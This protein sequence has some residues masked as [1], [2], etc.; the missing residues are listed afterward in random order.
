MTFAARAVAIWRTW[1]V[2]VSLSVLDQAVTSG[3]NLALNV[4]LARLLAPAAYGAFA[5]AYAVL[6]IVTGFHTALFT[7]PLSALG[8]RVFSGDTRRYMRGVMALNVAVTV[9]L[10]V[11]VGTLAWIDAGPLIRSREWLFAV[12]AAIP[13][14]LSLWLLRSG[15]YLESRPGTALA[16]SVTYAVVLFGGLTWAHAE[17]RVTAPVAL[18]LVG[19]A[20]AIACVPLAF[21]TGVLAG[22]WSWH[23]ATT[24]A[25]AHWQF[26]R[27]ILG[28]SAAHA[29]ANGMYVPLLGAIAGLE[30]SA[31]LRALQN[32]QTPLVRV[33]AGISMVA[34]PLMAQ[35]VAA[36]GA[37]YLKERGT[38]FVMLNMALAAAYA[39]TLAAF[40]RPIFS[41]L[42]GSAFY[43]SYAWL[44]PLFAA[45]A[46]LAAL[47]QCLGILVR[48]ANRPAAVLWA[49][50]GA[51]LWLVVA[52]WA[53]LRTLGVNGAVLS[54]GGS[55]AIESAVYL[56]ALRRGRSATTA[57]TVA[58]TEDVP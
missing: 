11:L 39:L 3:A 9:P 31:V 38:A 36:Q 26:G 54:I 33:M 25:R 2:R 58:P 50:L 29:I 14:V 19:L 21:T 34:Y 8:T 46:L 52:G 45:A 51:A 55:A 5:V 22:P 17:S 1:R 49:K 44:V 41:L 12:G 48:V 18:M 20:S 56:V 42:Y 4:A 24:T 32:L 27:W 30:H 13:P 53:L 16:G 47:A 10:A 43:T 57:P 28:A 7:D 23:D 15:C 35:R 40:G 6:I 37:Q